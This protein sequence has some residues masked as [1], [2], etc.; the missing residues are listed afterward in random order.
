VRQLDGNDAALQTLVQASYECAG[1]WVD[2]I[3]A[4]AIADNVAGGERA[5]QTIPQLVL[6]KRA[7]LCTA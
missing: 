5:R 6:E 1:M 4:G 3:R 2:M 7:F